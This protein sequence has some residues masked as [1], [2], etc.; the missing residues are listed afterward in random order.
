MQS[1]NFSNKNSKKKKNNVSHM[2]STEIK[3]S[4]HEYTNPFNKLMGQLKLMSSFFRESK[5]TEKKNK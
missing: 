3:K 2:T 4:M 5:E 1:N